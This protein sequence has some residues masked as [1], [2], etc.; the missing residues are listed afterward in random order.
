MID[1][2]IPLKDKLLVELIHSAV[3][4]IIWFERNN[5]IFKDTFVSSISSLG[6]RMER[7]TKFRVFYTEIFLTK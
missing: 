7:N 1:Y 5:I 3:C 6:F 2:C 4:W